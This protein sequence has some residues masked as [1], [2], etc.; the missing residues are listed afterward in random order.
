MGPPISAILKGIGFAIQSHLKNVTAAQSS[1]FKSGFKGS[2]MS[3]SLGIT[4]RSPALEI[5]IAGAVGAGIYVAVAAGN[6]NGDACNMSPAAS[7]KA[8]TVGAS[9]ITDERAA[10]SNLGN[11]TDIFAPSVNVPAPGIGFDFDVVFGGG[12][13]AA[14]PHVAGLMAYFLSLQPTSNSEFSVAAITP[15]EMK[16]YLITIATKDKLKDIPE[17]T[18]NALAWNCA[19][20]PYKDC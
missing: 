1:Q 20:T 3:V 6:D 12:T 15:K 9:T 8:V 16:E 5:F 19:D 14:A 17:G 11:C 4:P 10:F 2:V 7:D 13:S 18:P